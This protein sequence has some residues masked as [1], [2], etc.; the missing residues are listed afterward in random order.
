M[1]LG[2]DSSRHEAAV[3]KGRMHEISTRGPAT[4]AAV[5]PQQDHHAMNAVALSPHVRPSAPVSS[6]PSESLVFTSAFSSE[7]FC[8]LN[9][10]RHTSAMLRIQLAYDCKHTHD[11]MAIVRLNN[12]SIDDNLLMAIQMMIGDIYVQLVFIP[13][14]SW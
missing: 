7:C 6:G 5:A 4:M 2:D 10:S 13:W 14:Q 11:M 9:L 8:S 1:F 12:D 3:E